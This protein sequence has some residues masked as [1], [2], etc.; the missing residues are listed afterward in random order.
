MKKFIT[1]L[2]LTVLAFAPVAMAEE[3]T[4]VAGMTGVT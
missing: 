1:T 3:I 4:Y 2:A